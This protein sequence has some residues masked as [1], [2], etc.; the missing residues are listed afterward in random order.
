MQVSILD[1]PEYWKL[2]RLEALEEAENLIPT[3]HQETHLW[4]QML[5]AEHW[6]L[7]EAVKI[8]MFQLA[9]LLLAEVLIPR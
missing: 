6:N 1:L 4:D 2:I 9:E 8:R 5:R 7:P 3:L